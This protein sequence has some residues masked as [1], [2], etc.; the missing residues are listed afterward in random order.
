MSDKVRTLEGYRRAKWIY[1]SL[2]VV[3]YFVPVIAVAACL[4]PTTEQPAGVSWA[5]GLA[6][7]AIH[8]LPF[9]GGIFRTLFSHLPSLNIFPFL[10]LLLYGFFTAELFQNYVAVFCWIEFAAAVSVVFSVVFWILYRKNAERLETAKT[11]KQ[12]GVLK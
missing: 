3:V 6:V 4:L 12:L 5:V 8:A 7:V 10:F 11:V 9:I 1:F 2:Y